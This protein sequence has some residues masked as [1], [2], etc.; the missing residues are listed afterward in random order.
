MATARMARELAMKVL[1][2]IDVGRLPADE[3]I[4]LAFEEVPTGASEQRYVRETIRGVLDHQPEIDRIIDSLAEGWRIERMANVDKNVLR[5]AIYELMRRP[6]AP[7]ARVIDH[8]V[9][10]AKKYS[11][12]ESGKFVNGILGAYVR[13]RQAKPS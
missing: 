4:T 7:P 13:Q 6:D 1:F 11:T 10:M 8:A 12:A 9:D 3:A 5:I 2:Q